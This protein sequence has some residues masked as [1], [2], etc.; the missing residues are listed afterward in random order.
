M[1][2]GDAA[3]KKAAAV[4]V[5]ARNHTADCIGTIIGWLRGKGTDLSFCSTK[6][7]VTI[8]GQTEN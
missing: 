8:D 2:L 6:R 4:M 3:R 7:N 5:I 1:L